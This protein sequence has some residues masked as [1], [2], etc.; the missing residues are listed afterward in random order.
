[1]NSNL[2]NVTI[3]NEENAAF[4]EQ[5]E[6]I[7]TLQAQNLIHAQPKRR[8]R[9]RNPNKVP[10]RMVGVYLSEAQIKAVLDEFESITTGV[11]AII[12]ARYNTK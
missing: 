11:R 3:Q 12:N 5:Q 2:S 1:M 9:P 6:L 8:G 4:L 10:R 7:A